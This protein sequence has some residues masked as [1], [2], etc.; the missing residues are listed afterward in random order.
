MDEHGA[1]DLD[2]LGS[3]ARDDELEILATRIA[4][5]LEPSVDPDAFAGRILRRRDATIMLQRRMREAAQ[6]DLHRTGRRQIL[7]DV[8]LQPALEPGE[9]AAAAQLT[10]D[11][12]AHRRML[13]VER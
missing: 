3:R 6:L 4:H 9:R 10:V 13:V 5:T 2:G 12:V 11:E 1:A 8:N 7:I